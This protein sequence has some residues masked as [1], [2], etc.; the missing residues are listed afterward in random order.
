VLIR[1]FSGFVEGV[2]FAVLFG[3]MCA[4]LM[5]EVVVRLRMRRF[6]REDRPA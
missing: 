1:S 2:M 5:D 6:A 3:N 4:P